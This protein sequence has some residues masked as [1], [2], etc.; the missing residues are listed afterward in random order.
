VDAEFQRIGEQIPV[1][2]THKLL[3]ERAP[4]KE[5]AELEHAGSLECERIIFICSQE[6]I[7]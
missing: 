7:E 5:F 6:R 2:Q 3:E 4:K 1:L